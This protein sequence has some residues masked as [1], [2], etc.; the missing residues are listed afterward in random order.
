MPVIGG[1]GIW[2]ELQR[3]AEE[4]RQELPNADVTDDVTA[5]VDTEERPN[6][7]RATDFLEEAETVLARIR[8][9]RAALD[10]VDDGSIVLLE[11]NAEWR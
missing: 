5:V 9:V 2:A 7:E 11:D 10:E 3:V 6:E 4:L 1:D 8:E